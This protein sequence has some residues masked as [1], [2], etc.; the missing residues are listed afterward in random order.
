MQYL[1]DSVME[2]WLT[3]L[4]NCITILNDDFIVSATLVSSV[5]H[6]LSAG[7]ISVSRAF[8]GHNLMDQ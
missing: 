2:K 4:R 6:L 7:V 3:V 1:Q 8:L 5:L